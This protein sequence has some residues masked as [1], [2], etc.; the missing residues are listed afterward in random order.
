MIWHLGLHWKGDIV[1]PEVS[2]SLGD[3]KRFTCEHAFQ[4]K[5]ANP[6]PLELELSYSSPNPPTLITSRPGTK[7]SGVAPVP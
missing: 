1:P 7:P 6:E 2:Q 3:G 4:Y 5:P